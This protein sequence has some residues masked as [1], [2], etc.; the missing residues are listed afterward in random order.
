MEQQQHS[1]ACPD[2]TFWPR[3]TRSIH[4]LK[5]AMAG[6]TS[7]PCR[8]LKAKLENVELFDQTALVKDLKLAELEADFYRANCAT[9]VENIGL[10]NIRICLLEELVEIEE[11]KNVEL[12][13]DI[14]NFQVS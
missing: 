4:A 14:Q 7:R 12:Q 2:Q 11:R 6:V 10:Y 3:E 1:L 9:R 13:K 8:D 5:F